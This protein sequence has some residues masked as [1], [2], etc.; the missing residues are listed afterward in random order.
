MRRP[1]AIALAA[2]VVLLLGTS[3]YFYN[4]NQKTTVAYTDMKTSEES[5]RSQ[6]ADAF[7][8]IAEIQDSLNAISD[9]GNKM[10]L[11]QN[12]QSELTGAPNRQQALESIA[13]LN[14]SIQKTKER[15]SG[16]E[17]SLHK[18]GV[19]MAGMQRMIA[20][21][22]DSVTSK[23]QQ[24]AELTGQVDNL[25]VQVT[26]LQT[27]VQ[28]DSVTLV[29]KDQTIEDKRKELGTIFYVVGSKDDL[30][31]T[32]VIEAKGGVL[33]LGKTVQLTGRYDSGQFTA[34]DTDQETVIHTTA[35]KTSKVKILS[36]QP[37]GSYEVVQAGTS[38]EIHILDPT[39]FRSV[40][41]L[42]I[43]TA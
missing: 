8:A 16:L 27:T 38:V 13:A 24:I 33:G 20:N 28:S 14:A 19:K 18:S 34:I 12:Q 15:I 21:L 10:E 2:A 35:D 23:E 26:G 17:A 40:K 6:Y 42:V 41:H 43:L 39:A 29:A 32:G 7:N 1:V 37:R 25:Q 3:V 36:A 9:R 5:V 4:Q 11:R 22:K 30:K 31:K